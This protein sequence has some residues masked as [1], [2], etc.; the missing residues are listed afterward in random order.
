MWSRTEFWTEDG[1][2]LSSQGVVGMRY[3]RY[4]KGQVARSQGHG[5]AGEIISI[6]ETA[7]MDVDEEVEVS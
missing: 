3:I 4:V 1:R 2:K 7:T 5:C 6:Y